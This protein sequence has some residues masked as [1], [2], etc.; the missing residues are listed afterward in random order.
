[1]TLRVDPYLE[2][3]GRYDAAVVRIPF[4]GVNVATGLGGNYTGTVIPAKGLV[5]AQ[6]IVS[7]S[8]ERP[9]K[10]PV[11][12]VWLGPQ[13]PYNNIT[14]GLVGGAPGSAEIEITVS[15]NTGASDS[16]RFVVNTGQQAVLDVATF[17]KGNVV[18]VACSRGTTATTSPNDGVE[19]H[20]QW[21]DARNP[22]VVPQPLVSRIFEAT[23]TPEPAP[24]TVIVVPPGGRE[25]I[26]Y[27]PLLIAMQDFNW[28]TAANAGDITDGKGGI[29]SAAIPV[30]PIGGHFSCLGAKRLSLN[31]Q[32]GWP[33]LTSRFQFILNPF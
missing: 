19:I 32:V 4:I 33:F 7:W 22:A 1:M 23:V 11:L 21:T 3:G 2:L 10:G 17:D 12:R 27:A 6:E 25:L 14:A 5:N 9:P 30:T 16:R 24:G 20:F 15:G 31:T 28:P 13:Q 8:A 18:L 29:P 26:A